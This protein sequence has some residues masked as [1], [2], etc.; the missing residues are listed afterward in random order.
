MKKEKYTVED[1]FT[2]SSPAELTYVKRENENKLLNRALKTIGKQII[3]YGNSGCGKTSLLNNKIKND[4]IKFIKTKC[5]KGMPFES[6]IINAFSQL[7]INY[8]DG[9]EK[10]KENELNGELGFD[11]KILAAKFGS[12]DKEN[13]KKNWKTLP[14]QLNEQNLA[15]TLGNLDTIWIIEDFHKLNPEEKIKLSQAMKVFMDTSEE[16][17]NLKIIATGA[18]NT[19]RQ[20]VEYDPEMNNR[21]SEIFVPLMDYDSL[22]NIIEKGSSLLNVEFPDSIKQKIIAYS[23]GLPSVTHQLSSLICES[24][25]I[26]GT[27]AK[28]VTFTTKDLDYA[29]D[30]Y[31]NEKSDTLKNTYEVATKIKKE[32][33]IF[34][35]EN[36]LQA[37]LSINKEEVSYQEIGAELKFRFKDLKANNLR[38]F[39]NELTLSERGEVIRY[40]KNADSYSFSNPFFKGYCHLKLMRDNVS[41]KNQNDVLK[42]ILD[43]EFRKFYSEHFDID[44]IGDNLGY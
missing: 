16:Y 11:I 13:I 25:E 20:V 27:V 2:P 18:V 36:I 33:K 43:E 30:E 23:N 29:I 40:N 12:G 26:S 10:S 6:I 22:N 38:V 42:E 15:K 24:R 21:V 17:K 34:K 39:L 35:P 5:V 37:I 1:V 9:I 3:I 28:K 4:S 32:R 44:D 14:P 7:S 41:S 31:I 19:A 8:L